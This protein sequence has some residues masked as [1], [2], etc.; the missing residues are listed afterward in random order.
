MVSEIAA[1]HYL[2]LKLLCFWKQLASLKGLGLVDTFNRSQQPEP[3]HLSPTNQH[4]GLLPGSL[5]IDKEALEV[6]SDWKC[7]LPQGCSWM[8][9]SQTC[10]EL[11]ASQLGRWVRQGM[12]WRT[13]SPCTNPRV[14]YGSQGHPLRRYS[15]PRHVSNHLFLSAPTDFPLL[16]A[17]PAHCYLVIS[18]L[19]WQLQQGSFQ[20]SPLK[21]YL[22]VSAIYSEHTQ[23]CT[24]G[25]LWFHAAQLSEGSPGESHFSHHKINQKHS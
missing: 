20:S 13:V 10:M 2:S 15:F 8:A 19:A 12:S 1:L 4:E 3:C 24:A 21:I 16:L 17:A 23:T 18:D 11:G 9:L 7:D 5:H 25:L 22:T 6:F 14:D